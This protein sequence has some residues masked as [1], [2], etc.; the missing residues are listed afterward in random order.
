MKAQPRDLARGL[1]P[2]ART[3]K[4]FFLCG[5]DEAGASDAARAIIAALAAP[6]ERVDLTGAELR[7]DPALLDDT[8]RSTSLFGATRHIVAQVA[9]EDAHDAIANLLAGMAAAPAERCPIIVLASGATDKSRS[10]KLLIDRADAVVAVFYPADEGAFASE[11]RA[12]GEAMGLGFGADLAQR[13]ARGAGR[14]I[15][16]A[17]S[18]LTKLALYCDAAPERPKRLTA[19]DLDAVGAM[20]ADDGVGGV[21][22]AVLGGDRTALP[23]ELRRARETEL[24]PVAVL[25]AI[26]RRAGVLGQ[27]AARLGPHEDPARLVEAEKQ[28]RRIFWSDAPAIARQLRL[29][30]GPRA[31]RL[32]ARLVDL[33]RALLSNSQDAALLL[34]D[35]LTAITREAGRAR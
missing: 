8:A 25:L 31:S 17:M 14:D 15:R 7:K 33:H 12:R 30:R 1:P 10:A 26:E 9:G 21:V 22:D 28:A 16:L 24:N 34:A 29:W 32:A 35:G 23:A 3:A 4:L 18:E 6:G 27:L 5:P 19:A 13:L 2:A 20:H 11:I